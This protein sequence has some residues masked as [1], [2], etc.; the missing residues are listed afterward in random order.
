MGGGW[1]AH[2]PLSCVLVTSAVSSYVRA[3]QRTV[4]RRYRKRGRRKKRR[5]RRTRAKEET[6]GWLHGCERKGFNGRG[7]SKRVSDRK[8]AERTL[9][10]FVEEWKESEERR[11]EERRYVIKRIGQGSSASSGNISGCELPLASQRER[12]SIHQSQ[13]T[14]RVETVET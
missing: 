8:E 12:L 7:A 13:S 9:D 14:G 4:R 1:K 6:G 3:V 5:K 11:G 10:A 2:W